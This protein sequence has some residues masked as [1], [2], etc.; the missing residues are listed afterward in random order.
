M[1]AAVLVV[2]NLP[3]DESFTRLVGMVHPQKQRFV[4]QLDSLR[5]LTG[6]A[7]RSSLKMRK[8]RGGGGGNLTAIPLNDHKVDTPSA[9]Y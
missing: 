4:R 7:T 6:Q 2:A 8:G 9:K 1:T 5:V 3:M